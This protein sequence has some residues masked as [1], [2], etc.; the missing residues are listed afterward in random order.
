MEMSV[1]AQRAALLHLAEHVSDV[2]RHVEPGLAKGELDQINWRAVDIAA[3]EAVLDQQEPGWSS[4]FLYLWADSYRAR[5]QW[6]LALTLHLRSLF[7]ALAN[8][9][10]EFGAGDLE[11]LVPQDVMAI[12]RGLAERIGLSDGELVGRFLVESSGSRWTDLLSPA[13]AA[14]IF[15]KVLALPPTRAA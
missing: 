13:A 10:P 11:D 9:V 12:I 4:V 15:A 5:R 8:F 6:S 3:L 14:D 1:D 2:R 7:D